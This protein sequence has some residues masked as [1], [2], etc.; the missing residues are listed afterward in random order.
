MLQTEL[1]GVKNYTRNAP[2]EVG[3][4]WK[5]KQQECSKRIWPVLKKSKKSKKECSKKSWQVLIKTTP[6]MLQK[7]LAS[8]EKNNTR[9]APK[10]VGQCWKK[11]K[12]STP[13]MRRK[14]LASVEK[15]TTPGMLQKLFIILTPKNPSPTLKNNGFVR[16][17]L[18]FQDFF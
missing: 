12:K 15:Q 3:Q 8:V 18:F 14:E 16:W 5:K 10:G 6:G 2:K 1:A 9:N 17:I 13:G 4:C 7:E 11:Q